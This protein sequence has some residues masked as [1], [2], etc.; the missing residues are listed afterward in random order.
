MRCLRNTP[1]LPTF[2]EGRKE[3][4]NAP[5]RGA[6][7]KFSKVIDKLP[8]VTNSEKFRYMMIFGVEGMM[9]VDGNGV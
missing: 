8:N 5:N 2:V 7:E 6:W 4:L 9:K 1:N 3:Y